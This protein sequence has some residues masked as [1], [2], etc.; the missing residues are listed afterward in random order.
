MRWNLTLIVVAALLL[1][2]CTSNT[3][4]ANSED[5]EANQD[6]LETIEAQP[7]L[8]DVFART[9][10]SWDG[11]TKEGAFLCTGPHGTGNCPAGQQIQPDNQHIAPLVFDHNLTRATFNL[12]WTPADATQFGLAFAAYDAAGALLGI[13]EGPGDLTLELEGPGIPGDGSAYLIVWPSPKA[14]TDPSVY[15]DVTRQAY[16]VEG[17]IET[18]NQE[19]QMP[20]PEPTT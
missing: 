9:P 7:V 6:P 18:Q 20:E 8:V 10:F 13:V 1:A 19:W 2:G 14:G 16:S 3:P 5:S 17:F 15:V 4:A 12:T 11:R